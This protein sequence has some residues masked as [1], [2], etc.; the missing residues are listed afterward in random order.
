VKHWDTHVWTCAPFDYLYT[1]KLK[2]GLVQPGA[3]K[4]AFGQMT[5]AERNGWKQMSTALKQLAKTQKTL[6]R[7]LDRAYDP[8]CLNT[9]LVFAQPASFQSDSNVFSKNRFVGWCTTD[10]GNL[11]HALRDLAESASPVLSQEQVDSL[12]QALWKEFTNYQ[13][14]RSKEFMDWNPA[15]TLKAHGMPTIGAS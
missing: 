4:A 11:V 10:Q 13:G 14:V 2:R 8:S 6:R 3:G 15:I 7:L 12:A 5:Q 9:A 1:H